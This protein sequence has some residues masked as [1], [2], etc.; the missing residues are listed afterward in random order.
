MQLVSISRQKTYPPQ[1]LLAY[2]QTC[3]YFSVKGPT[4]QASEKIKECILGFVDPGMI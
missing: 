4:K 3:A 2:T 1:H